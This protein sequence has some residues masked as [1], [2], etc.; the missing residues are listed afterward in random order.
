MPPP[1]AYRCTDFDGAPC[2]PAFQVAQL[3]CFG[4]GTAQLVARWDLAP[5][6][7]DYATSEPRLAEFLAALQ[8]AGKFHAPCQL[9][10]AGMGFPRSGQV[11]TSC[12]VDPAFR[13][14]AVRAV[15]AHRWQDGC[16]WQPCAARAQAWVSTPRAL[17]RALPHASS[18]RPCGTPHHFVA[19]SSSAGA[20][21]RN[22]QR[23]RGP[24]SCAPSSSWFAT[25]CCERASL[26]WQRGAR[27]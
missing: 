25:A 17:T 22:K 11:A 8:E 5:P 3:H 24:I 14:H 21:N 9:L 15:H 13:L 19:A 27:D 2:A 6:I 23:R 12:S 16:G 7:S 20:A 10:H 4:G 1:A 26:V 18:F